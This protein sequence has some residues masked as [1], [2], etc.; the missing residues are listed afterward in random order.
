MNVLRNISLFVLSVG[1]LAASWGQVPSNAEL[2]E[3]LRE[4]DSVLFRAAFDTCDPDTMASLFSKDFEFYHDKG[5]PTTGRD[6]FLKPVYEQ[7]LGK[8]EQWI[9]PSRRILLENSLKVFPL[10]ENGELYGAIQEGQHRFEFLNKDR[11]YQ[12]GDIARFIH[13]WVLEEGQWKIKRELSYDH[14]PA[15]SYTLE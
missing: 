3:T 9:P 6:T 7:C 13:L 4:K 5:G 8:D 14:R 11:Q 10:R 1:S 12:R 15:G 2:F